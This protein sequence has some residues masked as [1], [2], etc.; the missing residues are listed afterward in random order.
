[1]LREKIRF[2]VAGGSTTAF[3]Y[4]LYA[5][6]LF[7][8][9]AAGLAYG[10]AYVAGIGW[11]YVVNSRWVFKTPMTLAGLLKFPAVYVVQALASFA[12]FHLLH[13]IL[14]L[15]SLLVPLLVAAITI[16][17]T[18]LISRHILTRQTP[19]RRAG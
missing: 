12:L 16:P 18:Y 5:A 11:A 7:A 17:L 4:A 6:L 1:M 15:D 10:I 8:D 13:G 14:R 2:I 9:I 19:T 3:S